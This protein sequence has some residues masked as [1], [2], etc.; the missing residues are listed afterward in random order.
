MHDGLAVQ[1]SHVLRHRVRRLHV[2]LV[3]DD[4]VWVFDAQC[5]DHLPV[6]RGH[7]V[8]VGLTLS[9]LQSSLILHDAL[10]HR[11]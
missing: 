3:G 11:R 6:Q 2:V 4:G 9:K 1:E 10:C 7:V 5:V 8:D